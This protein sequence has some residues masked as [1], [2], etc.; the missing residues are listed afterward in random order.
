MDQI[1]N[2]D[3]VPQKI[4]KFL[5]AMPLVLLTILLGLSMVFVIKQGKIKKQSEAQIIQIK[6]I[7]PATPVP[8]ITGMVV[9]VIT[10]Y[11]NPFEEKTQY[12]NPFSGNENPFDNLK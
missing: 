11:D 12:K 3:K 2:S 5:I 9:P 4:S 6:N 7:F 1:S 8:T 10:K